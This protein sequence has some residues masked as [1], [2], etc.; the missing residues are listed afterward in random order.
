MTRKPAPTPIGVPLGVRRLRSTNAHGY[1]KRWKGSQLQINYKLWSHCLR[2]SNS[3]DSPKWLLVKKSNHYYRRRSAFPPSER[4]RAR[5]VGLVRPALRRHNLP[6]KQLGLLKSGKMKP[7]GS[8]S[9]LA[10]GDLMKRMTL[11]VF[12]KRNLPWP[13]NRPGCHDQSRSVMNSL[14]F[15]SV[16]WT[17]ELNG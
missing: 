5:A 11:R 12:E 2:G 4:G 10:T 8:L 16:K 6:E 13:G 14:K 17:T 9:Q 3:W 7:P 1:D 15:G